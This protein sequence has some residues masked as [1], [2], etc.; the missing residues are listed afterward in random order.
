M[1]LA[2]IEYLIDH[3]FHFGALPIEFEYD[4]TVL[5]FDG[6]WALLSKVEQ[7]FFLSLIKDL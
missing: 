4:D 1:K 5:D 6:Y 2:L 3:M 7:K